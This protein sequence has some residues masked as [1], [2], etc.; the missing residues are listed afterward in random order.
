MSQFSDYAENQVVDHIFRTSSFTKP[1]T[2]AVA[3]FTTAPS[4]AAGGTEV[5]G[6]SYARVALNPLNTNWN[7]TQGGTAGASSGTGG[8]T[9]NATAIT[10]AAP[11][12]NWGAVTAMGIF[13]ATSGG[14]LLMWD[15]LRP[16]NSAW[17]F[18]CNSTTD[19]LT[20]P[21]HTLVNGDQ[22]VLRTVENSALPTGG[23]ANTIYFVI[24]VSGATLQLSLT[25]GGA[26][27]NFSADGAGAILK[28]T[29]KTINNGDSAPSFASG[30]LD[31]VIA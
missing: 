22:V 19:V 20:A 9:D 5:T 15:F 6:G 23:S 17:A 21:A 3:L 8:L 24:G 14:N 11:T 27:I 30:A 12:A 31:V 2:L 28:V 13:D 16:T 18:T 4:D 1:T 7:A 10:F 26:A 25:S 29:P